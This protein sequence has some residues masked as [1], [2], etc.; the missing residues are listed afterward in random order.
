MEEAIPRFSRYASFL[1]VAAWRSEDVQLDA[2]QPRYITE[3]MLATSLTMVIRN[4][5]SESAR[6]GQEGLASEWACC[7]GCEAD[8]THVFARAV[9]LRR[10]VS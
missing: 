7:S 9:M 5:W 6:S 2:R 8:R 4:E 3:K 10:Y 1:S